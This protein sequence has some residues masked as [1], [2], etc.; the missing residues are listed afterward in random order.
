MPVLLEAGPFTACDGEG[1]QLFR[2]AEVRLE[3]GQATVL[4]GP[5]GGGKSTLLRHIAGLTWGEHPAT[6]RLGSEGYSGSTIPRWRARV[7]LMSQDAPMVPG[8][9]WH[10][11]SLPF[12]FRCSGDRSVDEQE[13]RAL[14]DGVGLSGLPEDRDVATVSG[15]ERHRLALARGLLWDPPVLLADEPLAGL[16]SDTA[17]ACFDLLLAFAHRDGHALL[18]VLHD[19]AFSDRADAASRLSSGRFEGS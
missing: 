8:S 16:D 5:S 6:R 11:L 2:A 15:G 19:G 14:L 1:R 4:G 13:A 9:V 10:N 3:E 7:S 17:N 18:V 12:S